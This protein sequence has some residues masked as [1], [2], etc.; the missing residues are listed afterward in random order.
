[1]L[2]LAPAGLA[3]PAP[4]GGLT[5]AEARQLALQRNWDQR[6]AQQDVAIADAQRAVAHEWP[7]PTA[8]ISSTH[9]NTDGRGNTPAA[10]NRVWDRSYDSVFSLTQPLEIGGKRA[11]RQA[12][13]TA[14]YEGTRA[15]LADNQRT[16]SLAVTRAYVGAA[17]ADASARI[18]RDSAAH[19]RKEAEVAAVRLKAGDIGRSELDRIEIAARQMDLQ[20]QG[21]VASAT[22]QRVALE[23]LLGLERPTGELVLRESVESLAG[24]SPAPMPA[25]AQEVSR[26]DLAVAEQAL[27]KAEADLRLQRAQRIPDPSLLIQYEHQPPDSPNSIGLGVSFPLPIWNRNHGSIRAAT[28]ARDQAALAVNKLKAQI[29]ADLAA[30]RVAYAEAQARWDDYRAQVRPRAEQVRQS[31]ALAYEKGG[32]S[33]L[34]L[35]EAQRSESDVQQAAAQ[36]AADAAVARATLEAVTTPFSPSPADKP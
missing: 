7:N 14:A 33:L 16:L 15:Q 3:Q 25:P 8:S 9:I 17:L 20:A 24:Q 31:V 12:S 23:S 2:L 32:A 36:A 19:L 5:L 22:G 28:T 27:R 21:A 6:S 26:A 13:A 1:M 29:A 10:S 18:A 4:T 35:L 11:A 30:A 34:D